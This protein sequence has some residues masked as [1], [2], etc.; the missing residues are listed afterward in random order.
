M[1]NHPLETP[2]PSLQLALCNAGS[3][4][5][6]FCVFYFFVFLSST[7]SILSSESRGRPDHM[8]S[9]GSTRRTEALIMGPSGQLTSVAIFPRNYNV[10]NDHLLLY[11]F[12]LTAGQ[13]Y[14]AQ[15][16]P[17]NG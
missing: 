5:C 1:K 6:A 3:C 15:T 13:N 4:A 8:A 10:F 17:R 2:L 12:R 14:K 11:H 16:L 7:A 9:C